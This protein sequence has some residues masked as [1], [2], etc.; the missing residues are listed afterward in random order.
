MN[1]SPR[2]LIGLSVL[3]NLVFAVTALSQPT[4]TDA[5][6]RGLSPGKPVEL[7]LHG[8]KLDGRL[9]IWCA[10]P[11][12]I[13]HITPDTQGKSVNLTI[14][15]DPAAPVG[16]TGLVV[17]NEFG[18]SDPL[19]VMV[20]DM[21]STHDS[22]ANHA[23]EEAQSITLP[24]AVDGRGDGVKSDYYRF[25]AQLG[26][27]ISIEVV[28][29]RMASSMD[30]VVRLLDSRQKEILLAD[31]DVGLGADC[32][33]QHICGQAGDYYI[34]VRDNQFQA[35]GQYRLR[36]G[37]FPMITST[38]P[39]GGRLGSTEVF[40]FA[41]ADAASM[42]PLFLA[43]PNSTPTPWLGMSVQAVGGG[44]SA[45]TT[46]A[47]SDLP[48]FVEAEPND[49]LGES[50]RVTLPCA[51][52]GVLG[53]EHDQDFYEFAATKDQRIDLTAHGRRFGSPAHVFMTLYDSDGKVAVETQVA[54]SEEWTLSYTAPADG[55]VYVAAR[56][57]L[58]RGGECFAYR[59]EMRSGPD[60]S[61]VLK[62]DQN[63]NVKFA[64]PH[65]DGAC[66]LTVEAKRRGYEG[67]IRLELQT[68][69]GPLQ[70]YNNVIPAKANEVRLFLAVPREFS[71]AELGMIRI[72]GVADIDGRKVRRT[73][74]T[75]PTLRT[76]MPH[77]LYPPS[78]Y[79][80]LI[81][82]VV[83]KPATPFFDISSDQQ[84]LKLTDGRG[85]YVF[86]IRRKDKDFKA[87][88]NVSF[89]ALPPGFETSV[90]ADKD[91]YVVALLGDEKASR[92]EFTLRLVSIGEHQGRGQAVVREI[93]VLVR[94]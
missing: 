61:L 66:G 33:L 10:A 88:V 86:R 58:R 59:I 77:V 93:P 28:A 67:P 57:L 87:G 25:H 24:S 62:N 13:E 17:A 83:V 68:T 22:G 38:L 11:A 8:D 52:S 44:C 65:G 91:E 12:S 79:D 32:R 6:P 9:K 54:P 14:T 5:T 21:I 82:T 80:G 64:L 56:D 70:A 46:I 76:K 60:F 34:E 75:E 78:W 1:Y 49:K 72:V 55:L 94:E 3:L 51:V 15:V 19:M 20:D 30:P 18:V 81:T 2:S 31:D 85:E 26:Q 90:K 63:A 29:Q 27:R 35:G 47:A 73:M 36:V 40:R 92:D 69:D 4:L 37:D 84:S 39:L 43:I 53:I 16:V 41:G 23:I 71:E 7:C 50:T 89:G 48:E 74:S 42:P 45:M